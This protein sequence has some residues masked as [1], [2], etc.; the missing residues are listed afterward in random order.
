[1]CWSHL[2]GNAEA[3]KQAQ[4]RGGENRSGAR[5][6]AKQWAAAGRQIRAE[7]LPHMLKACILRVASGQMEPA[8]ASAI[9]G[10]AKASVQLSHDLE[11]EGRIAALEAV[12]ERRDAPNVRRIG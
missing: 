1:V 12:I 11:L 2:P 6:A 7:E 10:L 8:Q 9:A 5:R 3:V 4:R